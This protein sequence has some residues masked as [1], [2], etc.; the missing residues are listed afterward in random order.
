MKKFI[1]EI[2]PYLIVLVIVILVKQFIVSP[3]QVNG[4]SMYDTLYNNDIMILNKLAYKFNDIERFDIVVINYEGRHLIKRVI[5]LPG[6]K[7]K[8]EDNKLYINDEYVEE[9]YLSSFTITENYELSTVIP[10]NYY[11][12][13][14]DNRSVS[15][16]SRNLGLFSKNQIEG[17]ASLTIFP[18]G[19]FGFKE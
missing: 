2:Y 5:G 8:I 3:I 15:L 18:F 10:T 16:D 17:K 9:P 11:F 1:K 14:G 7:I 12:V 6:D 19:R 4:D 13:L